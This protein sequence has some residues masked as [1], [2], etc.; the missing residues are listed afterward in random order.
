MRAE[1]VARQADQVLVG[2]LDR[3]TAALDMALLVAVGWDE[4]SEV[5]TPD[6]SHR[7]LGYQVCAVTGCGSE[8]WCKGPLCGACATRRARHPEQPI[9]AFL[10]GGISAR[11]PGE[12]LC[13]LCCLPGFS[14][15]A[16]SNGL[17]LSCDPAEARARRT[18]SRATVPSGRQ[19]L[20][21][22]WGSAR[23]SPVRASSP[24][25]STDCATRTI[26]LG[27][28]RAALT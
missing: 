15:P 12:R 4:K 5:F 14:R 3:L 27:G 8:A 22:R 26:R 18:S 7:L 6:R 9:E 16:I 1:A 13:A 19:N 2:D 25:R 28:W 10:A 20:A 23:C 17:C 21:Q 24:V 11:R